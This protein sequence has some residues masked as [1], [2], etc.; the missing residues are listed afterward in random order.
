MK[1]KTKT[2][3][4]GE[5]EYLIGGLSYPWII[6]KRFDAWFAFILPKKYENT[7]D[8][9]YVTCFETKK[10]AIDWL[11]SPAGSSFTW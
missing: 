6:A 10:E 5:S 1:K 8:G 3:S 4:L 9:E 7:N 11:N 2:K